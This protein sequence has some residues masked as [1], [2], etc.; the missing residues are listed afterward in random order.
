MSTVKNEVS[1]ITP[2]GVDERN[3]RKL[4]GQSFGEG[5]K[6]LPKV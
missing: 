2:E 6:G 1:G 5:Q 4:A 3:Q